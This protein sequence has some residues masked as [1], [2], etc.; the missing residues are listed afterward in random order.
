MI[1][2]SN[3]EGHYKLWSIFQEGIRILNEHA[4]NKRPLKY[5]MEKLI[6]PK[7]KTDKSTIRVEDFNN[8]L[9]VT[10]KANQKFW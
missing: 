6:E 4:A 8:P 5:M 1:F 10:G 7:G 3:K 2:I 9:S